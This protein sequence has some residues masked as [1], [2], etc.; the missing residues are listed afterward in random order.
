LRRIEGNPKVPH[1]STICAVFRRFSM[2]SV[3]D[4][5]PRLLRVVMQA[6]FQPG[7]YLRKNLGKCFKRLS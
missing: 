3:P 1:I 2:V 6:F 5:V 7:F 4:S